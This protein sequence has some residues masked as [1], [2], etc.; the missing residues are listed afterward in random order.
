MQNYVDVYTE[1]DWGGVHINSGI[2]NHAF[3]IIATALGGY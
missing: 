1:D 3:Y 2:P